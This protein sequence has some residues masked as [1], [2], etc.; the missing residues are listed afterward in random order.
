MKQL[1]NWELRP[2]LYRLIGDAE[3]PSRQIR[4]R[5]ISRY[6]LTV[7]DEETQ[8]PLEL[9]YASNQSSPFVKFQRGVVRPTH[10]NFIDGEIATDRAEVNLQKFLA[11]HPDNKAN[12]G[13]VFYEVQPELDAEIKEQE[14]RTKADA[15]IMVRDLSDEEIEAIIYN[16]IGERAFKTSLKE[17]RRDTY[18][19]AEH[20]PTMFIKVA[21]DGYV[22]DKGLAAKAIHREIIK[23]ADSN[24]TAIWASTKKKICA[25]SVDKS[26]AE[27][28]ADFFSTD[29]G[30]AIKSKVAEKLSKL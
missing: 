2:R 14:F 21:E 12:G 13:R 30:V 9:R 22:Q 11:V 28:I 6:P 10:V 29:D 23:L 7:L 16:E 27:G 3:P 25:L 1:D 26:P 15:F 18:I 4:T 8:E 20:N 17:L 19:L 24:R 5:H